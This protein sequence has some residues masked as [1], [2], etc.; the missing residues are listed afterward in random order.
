MTLSHRTEA[1]TKTC[2]A[3]SLSLCCGIPY[4]PGDSIVPCPPSH[5]N[6]D[7][8][9]PFLEP[10]AAGGCGPSLWLEVLSRR[11]QAKGLSRVFPPPAPTSPPWKLKLGYDSHRA[12][13]T[14]ASLLQTKGCLPQ[15]R[16]GSCRKS[17]HLPDSRVSGGP[18]GGSMIPSQQL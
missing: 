11:V 2:Y 7:L 13:S 9:I 12:P 17:Q 18:E 4:S 1:T 16:A 14:L 15:G 10:G 6:T 5:S 3:R 8:G